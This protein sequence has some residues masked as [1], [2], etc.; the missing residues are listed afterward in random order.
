MN[1]SDKD[2]LLTLA[3]ALLFVQCAT[4]D[5]GSNNELGP[6][7][8][9]AAIHLTDVNNFAYS[10]TIDIPVFETRVG[11]DL[12]ICWSELTQDMLC[13]ALDPVTQ[14]DNVSM[15]RFPHIT[16]EQIEQRVTRDAFDQADISGYVEF[17]PGDSTC[18]QQ[19]QMSFFGSPVD[20]TEEY[21]DDGSSYLLLL[22]TGTVAGKGVRMMAFLSPSEASDS[23]LVSLS[24]ACDMLDF[25]ARVQDL[26]PVS[27]PEKG[28][29][30]VDW[31]A[32]TV[33]GH[34]ETV[35]LE[36]ID[37]VMVAHYTEHTLEQIEARFVDLEQLA[38]SVWTLENQVKTSADLS[39]A[40]GVHGNF[41]GI[42]ATGVW[43]LALRC[44]ACYNPAPVFL[45]VLDVS[46]HED[47]LR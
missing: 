20:M 43:L 17:R 25:E 3:A 2:G 18:I 7:G 36:S 23:A 9:T 35:A 42:D 39:Q 32:L 15:L 4:G 6:E 37:T 11:T 13:H 34:G 45:T 19:S 16:H 24:S 26:T 21:K 33:N 31:S 14:V 44:E 47:S 46:P 5:G 41:S 10:G 27:L 1:T 28:P 29:W 30:I 38:S 40:T 12:S 8:S 22:S